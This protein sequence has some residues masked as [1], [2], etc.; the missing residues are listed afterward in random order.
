MVGNLGRIRDVALL[1]EVCQ[2]WK[3]DFEVFLNPTNLSVFFFP[4]LSF[5]STLIVD[6]DV[7]ST[8]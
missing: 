3:A 2:W 1:Q 5:F 8:Y 6:Q 4:S 7:M